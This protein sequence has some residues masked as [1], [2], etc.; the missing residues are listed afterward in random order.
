MGYTARAVHDEGVIKFQTRHQSRPLDRGR[1]GDLVCRLVAWRELLART[2]LVGQDPGRYGGAGYGNV[3]GR[4][5]APSSPQGARAMLISGTQTGGIVHLGLQ[6]FCV[7]ERYDYRINRVDSHGP[8]EPSSETMTHG[9]IYDLGPHIRYV[10]H[11]HSPIIWRSASALRLPTTRR[12]VAYGTPEMA[13]EVARLWRETALAETK[14]L[15]MGGHEDGVISFG[16]T[17]EEAGGVMFA[18]LARAF[19][20]RC[21]ATRR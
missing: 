18:Q 11:A 2:Q 10:L 8:I 20:G 17:L 12:D 6:H 15:A 3:S 7:V 14:I 13:Q 16:R 19:E 21:L 1:H 9:A 4:V 5:G